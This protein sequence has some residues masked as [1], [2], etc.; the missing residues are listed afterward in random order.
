MICGV[1][2]RK[3][4]LG[5]FTFVTGAYSPVTR[6]IRVLAIIV[7]G[8]ATAGL[9]YA[10]GADPLPS[11]NEGDAKQAIL[12]FV[13]AVTREDSPDFVP[14]PQRIATFDNDGTLW[15][16]QPMYVQLAFAIDHVKAL[17]PLHPDWKEKEPFQAV[18]AGDLKAL[19]A[20]GEKGLVQLVM[21][22][23]AG[24]TT[25]EF[26]KIVKDWL[27]TARHPRFDRPYTELVYQ[28]M[29]ELL[30]YLRA[31]GFKTFIVSGGGVEFMRPWTGAV[32]GIPPEQVI[33][34]S[35]KT[36]FE[37]RDGAPV[38]IRLPEVNFID[39]KAGKPAGINQGIGRRPIAAFGNSDGDLEMLQWTTV[40]EG[41]RR[42]GLIVHHTDAGREYAYD[43]K[44]AFGRLDVAL[45][46][47][48]ANGWVVVDMKRDWKRV[49]KFQ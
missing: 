19:A 46:A 30:S 36:R 41:G 15:V 1:L 49:F 18:L 39:D 34:S 12:G 7:L 9:A 31:N 35:I 32:Y 10:Q 2:T 24:M 23:H 28:P 6:R 25:D 16:E 8:A 37:M 3:T 11:W 45:D 4:I 5:A 13:A 29:I 48:A 17:A 22:T 14:A 40:R 26:A 33:G 42:L 21:E 44:S 43:R 27:A 38:L 20:S 47:A